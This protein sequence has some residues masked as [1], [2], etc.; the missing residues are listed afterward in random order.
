MTNDDYKNFVCIVAGEHPE[1]LMEEYNKKKKIEPKV[2]YRYKDA[3]KLKENYVRTYERILSE[4]ESD[5]NPQ[6]IEYI[7][8]TIIELNEMDDDEF[9][10]D[11]VENLEIDE[12]TGDAY[13]TENIDGKWS[14]YTIG[15]LFSVPFLKKDGIETFQAKKGDIAWDKIHLNG[16]EIYARAWEMV[17]DGSK[18]ETDYEQQIYDNMKDKAAY[19]Q[20]FETKENYV[21]SN[22]CFWGYAFLSEKTG[23]QEASDMTEQFAW[24]V[25]FFDVFIKPLSDDTLLTIYECKK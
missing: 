11:L 9:Y 12:K 17:M 5:L 20:K 16:G 13:T 15:K 4:R 22:T 21:A 14:Y 23:W 1:K 6:D 10:C 2:V 25:N 7:K 24:M 18:P 8:D 3:H 19:F